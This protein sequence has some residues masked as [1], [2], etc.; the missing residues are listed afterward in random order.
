MEN[1]PLL[2]IDETHTQST[3]QSMMSSRKH[4]A[5]RTQS[6]RSYRTCSARSDQ[7]G[8]DDDD[9]NSLDLD[10]DDEEPWVMCL[11]EATSAVDGMRRLYGVDKE[12]FY[13]MGDTIYKNLQLRFEHQLGQ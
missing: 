5:R 13:T 9:D 6:A 10:M 1:V 7:S 4:S 11:E 2:Q 3:R 8:L 12:T